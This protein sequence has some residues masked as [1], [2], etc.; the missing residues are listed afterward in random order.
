MS[1]RKES[2]ERPLR[3]AE[4][5]RS[6]LVARLALVDTTGSLRRQLGVEVLD[7]EDRVVEASAER[8]QQ[9]GQEYAQNALHATLGNSVPQ[10]PEVAA[11]QA[12]QEALGP[13][14]GFS[15]EVPIQQIEQMNRDDFRLAA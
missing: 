7:D 9:L 11:H 4:A 8:L 1:Y 12:A 14:P 5:Y 10:S 3:A 6:G 13:L 2:A 15:A